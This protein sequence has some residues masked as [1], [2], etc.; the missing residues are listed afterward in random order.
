MPARD[1]TAQAPTTVQERASVQQRNSTIA[2]RSTI[3]GAKED[4]GY[5]EMHSNRRI[6]ETITV[7]GKEVAPYPYKLNDSAR[8]EPTR[9]SVPGSLHASSLKKG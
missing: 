6:P 1:T 4:A 9:D 2:K 8:S 7:R 5:M 3:A